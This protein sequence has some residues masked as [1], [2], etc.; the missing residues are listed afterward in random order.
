MRIFVAGG[1]GFFGGHLVQELLRGGHS[2]RLLVHRRDALREGIDQFEGDSRLTVFEAYYG[3]RCP[4]SNLVGIIRGFHRSHLYK[5]ACTGHCQ[6]WR[7]PVRSVRR[8][9]RCPPSV[10]G[11]MRFKYH[12]SKWQAEELVRGG[13]EWTVFRPPDLP[14]R[15]TLFINMLAAGSARSVMPVIGRQCKSATCSCR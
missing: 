3:L 13:L 14:G 12:V 5:A 8:Y 10:H 9:C 1:T 6:S 7:Q 2:V 4:S 11:P 15:R